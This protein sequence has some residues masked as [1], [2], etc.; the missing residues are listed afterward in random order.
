M[1][2]PKPNNRK[3]KKMPASNPHFEGEV[4]ARWMVQPG[5]DRKMVLLKDFA[6]VDSG[7]FKWEADSGDVIDGA[8]IPELVWSHVVGTPFIGDYRRASVVHDVAC[9][10]FIKTSREAHRMF[11]EAMIADGTPKDKA[12]LFY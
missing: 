7:G 3:G 10:H 6:F 9:D 11:Y 4:E 1:I 8:S 12:L 2:R 5:E